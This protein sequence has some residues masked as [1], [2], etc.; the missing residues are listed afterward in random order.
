MHGGHEAEPGDDGGDRGRPRRAGP[1]RRTHRSAR[2]WVG[3]SLTCVA[4]AIVLTVSGF[5]YLGVSDLRSIGNS[6][7]IVSGPSTGPQNI[8][9]MGLESRTYW[10]GDI[11][12]WSILKYLHAGSRQAI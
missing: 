10:N 1:G 2:R 8:L 4:A 5:A 3:Y 12:P 11:L 6:H 7:A 9:L